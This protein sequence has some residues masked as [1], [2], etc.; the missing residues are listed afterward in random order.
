[1]IRPHRQRDKGSP[2]LTQDKSEVETAIT[3]VLGITP[4]YAEQMHLK[5]EPLFGK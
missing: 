2:P 1:M 3:T 4:A 5:C